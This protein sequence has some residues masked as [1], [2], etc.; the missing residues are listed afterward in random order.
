MSL[1]HRW[2]IVLVLGVVFFSNSSFAQNPA[3]AVVGDWLVESADAVIRI[4]RNG[5]GYDGHIVWQLHDHYGPEDGPQWNGK[6]VVDRNNPDPALRSRTLDGM[7][8]MWDLRYDADLQEWTGGRVYDS[9]DGHT[10]R[11]RLRLEDPSHL[12]LRGYVGI[13][14]L[15]GSS[16]WTRVKEFPKAAPTP[17]SARA[18]RS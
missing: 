7:R 4:T 1:M 12:R 15:G 17:A 5:D 11:C 10:Y 18:S 2:C 13:P 6:I 8:L 3:D 9:D 16:V 14:L